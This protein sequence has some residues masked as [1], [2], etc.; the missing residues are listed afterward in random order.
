MGSIAYLA[1]D[2]F[3]GLPLENMEGGGCV[4]VTQACIQL[5]RASRRVRILGTNIAV[6]WAP[7]EI[8]IGLGE[9]QNLFELRLS[10]KKPLMN[11]SFESEANIKNK[12]EEL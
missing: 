12:K 3:L 9:M 4:V 7:F 11:Y 5:P 8:A 6:F 10:L 1:S 2:N